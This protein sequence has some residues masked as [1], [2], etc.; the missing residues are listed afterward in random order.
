MVQE[1]WSGLLGREEIKGRVFGS[2]WALRVSGVGLRCFL[3]DIL[4]WIWG[5]GA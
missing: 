3:D 5:I 2:K 4:G 1:Y